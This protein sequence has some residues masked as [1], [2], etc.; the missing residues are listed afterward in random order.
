MASTQLEV[1]SQRHSGHTPAPKDSLINEWL[2][3]FA[4]NAG[5]ALGE[6]ER[7][8][9]LTMWKEGF[10]DVEAGQLHAAFVACL[11]SHTY[12]TM[13]TIGDVRQHL[14][15]A[16]DGAEEQ[17]A[18][19][20]FEQVLAYAVRRSP[21][22]PE[23]NPPRISERTRRAINAAG[24]LDYLR[25]CDRESLQWA[26]KRFIEAYIRYAEL[27]HDEH[28]LPPGELRDL[29]AGAAEQ[30]LLPSSGS[31]EDAHA[32]GLAYTQGLKESGCEMPHI[33]RAIRAVAGEV[34]PRPPMRPLDEQKRIIRERYPEQFAKAA[35]ALA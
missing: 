15:K 31:Y 5:V 6:K 28:L 35:R 14:Q 8:V 18:A 4:L 24:G 9:Y 21:D 7:A 26:R 13:P 17:G 30:R 16:E 20:K 19:V 23:K 1:V 34:A 10:A 22:I 25:D 2:T 27:H 33:K 12:K 29:L 3:R 11:R 32:R